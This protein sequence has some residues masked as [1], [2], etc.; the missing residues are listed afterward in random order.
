ML[1]RISGLFIQVVARYNWSSDE[2]IYIVSAFYIGYVITNLLGGVL[3]ERFG[4][5]KTISYILFISA[6]SFSVIPLIV[7]TYGYWTLFI[8][9]LGQGVIE[10]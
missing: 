7:G 1:I 5:T 6:G 10:V 4:A 3:S 8:L 2:Q 9:R